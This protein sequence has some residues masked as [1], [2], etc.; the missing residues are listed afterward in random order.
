MN[1]ISSKQFRILAVA[2]STRGFG[3]AVMEGEKTIIECATRTANGKKKNAQ[4]II[5]LKKLFDS[6]QPGVLVLQDALECGLL[7]ILPK[8]VEHFQRNHKQNQLL[9]A[10]SF[11]KTLSNTRLHPATRCSSESWTSEAVHHP[12][13]FCP[14][15]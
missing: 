9:T 15:S 4:S 5:K 1:Q 3:F 2:P 11:C 14:S 10:Y 12:L 8:L 7:P 6:Y 13:R